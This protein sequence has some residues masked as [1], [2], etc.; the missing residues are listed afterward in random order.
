MSIGLLRLISGGLAFAVCLP[1]AGMTASFAASDKA[2]HE[3]KEPRPFDETRDAMADVDAAL[4]RAEARGVRALLVLGGNW[5]HD[6]RGLAAK[7]GTPALAAL[8]AGKYELV[9]VDVG[10]RDR[11]L[12]V[13]KR[14][15]V[16]DLLGTP[17]VLIVSPAGA[18]LNAGSVH[19]WRDAASRSQ[20]EILAYFSEQAG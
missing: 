20:A 2:A 10:R 1:S 15:G 6:S 13:A 8:I 18:L 19:D 4:A 12:D 7:F 17:T 3:N 16:G 14:F 11:N 5:C 9:W